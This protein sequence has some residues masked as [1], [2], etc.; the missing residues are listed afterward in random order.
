MF[1][2]FANTVR[3]WNLSESPV[4]LGRWRLDYCTYTVHRKV[5]W[6]NEDHCGVCNSKEIQK[7]EEGIQYV[8]MADLFI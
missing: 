6:S 1:R 2:F 7:Q 3:K 5:L 8:M 4:L